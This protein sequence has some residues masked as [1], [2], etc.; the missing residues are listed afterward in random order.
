M[1]DKLAEIEAR[2][3]KTTPG[4]WVASTDGPCYNGTLCVFRHPIDDPYYMV[5]NFGDLEDVGRE[6]RRNAKAVAAAPVDVAWL[7]AEVKRLR[8]QP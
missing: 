1:S 7:I 3:A 8:G 5:A 2:W 4:P 6:D